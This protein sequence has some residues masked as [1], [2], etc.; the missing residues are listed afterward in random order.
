MA[1][2]WWLPTLVILNL[3]VGLPLYERA[4]VAVDKSGVL[5]ASD[6]VGK[7]V[8]DTDGKK[9]RDIKDYSSILRTVTLNMP[10]WILGA[11]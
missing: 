5:K 8:Q 10:S 4:A 7:R 2:L 11:F 3:I 6:L 1:R 9:L